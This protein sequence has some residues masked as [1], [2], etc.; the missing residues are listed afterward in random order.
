MLLFVTFLANISQ[1]H[2]G[3]LLLDTPTQDDARD[4]GSNPSTIAG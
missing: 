4:A 3:L 2:R 1:I